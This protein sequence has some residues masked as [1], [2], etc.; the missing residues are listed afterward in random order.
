MVMQVMVSQG[1]LENENDGLFSGNVNFTHCHCFS[2][3][4][5]H[6]PSMFLLNYLGSNHCTPKNVTAFSVGSTLAFHKLPQVGKIGKEP[7]G[8]I[9]SF[10][11]AKGMSLLHSARLRLDPGEHSI[12]ES[13]EEQ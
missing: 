9:R 6:L 10:I 8:N 3:N 2:V 13:A 11:C 4:S 12:T 7:T 1:M 5:M